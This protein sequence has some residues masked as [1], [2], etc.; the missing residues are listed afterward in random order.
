MDV[1]YAFC[2]NLP[3]KKSLSFLF[4]CCSDEIRAM[5]PSELL[6][7]NDML[8]SVDG[9]NQSQPELFGIKDKWLAFP[10]LV[11]RDGS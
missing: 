10:K 2:F 11:C 5:I 4:F 8:N 9:G 1:T 7:A 3:Y 6:H